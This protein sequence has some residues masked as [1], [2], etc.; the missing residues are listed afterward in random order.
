M[1]VFRFLKTLEESDEQMVNLILDA[2]QFL[3]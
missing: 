2:G 1:Y 3:P